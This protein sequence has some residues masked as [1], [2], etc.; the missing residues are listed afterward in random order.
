M[1]FP[2]TSGELIYVCD[3]LESTHNENNGQ[4]EVLL[5]AICNF[6]QRCQEYQRKGTLSSAQKH[7]ILEPDWAHMPKYNPSMG[8]MELGGLTKAKLCN[9]ITHFGTTWAEGH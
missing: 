4:M 3:T 8:K 5:L 2:Q 6:I 7:M 9:K 1:I